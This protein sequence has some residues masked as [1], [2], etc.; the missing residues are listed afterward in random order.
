[1]HHLKGPSTFVWLGWLLARRTRLRQRRSDSY[2][3]SGSPFA[4]LVWW[5][6]PE[7]HPDLRDLGGRSTTQTAPREP[8]QTASRSCRP[9]IHRRQAPCLRHGRR[10]RSRCVGQGPHHE[11]RTPV[12]RHPCPRRESSRV[13]PTD[14]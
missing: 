12:R 1:M 6:T 4:V 14:G 13:H 2:S 3:S 11:V 5:P 7:G 9:R 8:L 10:S